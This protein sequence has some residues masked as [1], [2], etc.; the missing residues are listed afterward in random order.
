MKVNIKQ[1][2]EQ[3]IK[4]GNLK[5]KFNAKTFII[6]T[7]VVFAI[8]ICKGGIGY[9]STQNFQV[10]Q[11]MGGDMSIQSQGGYYGKFFPKVWTYDKVRTIYFSSDR[12]ESKDNDGL[13]VRFANKGTG[14]VSVQVI[15]RLFS[16]PETMYKLHAYAR[17]DVGIIENI[18]FAK[19]K[20]IAMSVASTMSSNDAIENY[21]KFNEG[22]RSKIINNAELKERGIFIEQFS[23][24]GISF[25]KLTTGQFQKQQEIELARK[26][27]EANKIKF[28]TERDTVK[29]QYEKEQ[30]EPEGKAKVVMIKETTDAEREKKLA[31]I[32]AEKQVAVAKLAAEQAKID[33]EKVKEVAI[34]EATKNKE[35]AKLNNEAAKLDAERIITL[36]SAKQK[37][38]EL[39]KG[40]SELDKFKMTIDKETSIGV[41]EAWA[42]GISKMKLP[43]TFMLGGS[44]NQ[45]GGMNPM[46]TFFNLM[47]VSTAK[48]LAS[49]KESE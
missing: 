39:A 31:E 19:L 8:I 27:A 26:E 24:T 38:L 18:I 37:E 6:A 36:A 17:G 41:A 23:I 13:P 35:T 9:N 4:K 29:I 16:T 47:N 45:G 14:T 40:L 11:S 22:I 25:D 5:M 1:A 48:E 3:Q 10:I 42:N 28:E 34:V 43:E 44:G 12:E 46:E 7:F 21:A 30:A 15:A 32:A 20:E 33:A 49:K 2:I